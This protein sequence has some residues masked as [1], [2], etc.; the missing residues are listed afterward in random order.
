M[1]DQ[2]LAPLHFALLELCSMARVH[3]LEDWAGA[4]W[5]FRL[6]FKDVCKVLLMSE[7]LMPTTGAHLLCESIVVGNLLA[8]SH[9]L[10]SWDWLLKATSRTHSKMSHWSSCKV[11]AISSQS[12]ISIEFWEW[13]LKRR[14]ERDGWTWTMAWEL[15]GV[16]KWGSAIAPR[17]FI[18][19]NFCSF[20]TAHNSIA[21][22]VVG[23][24]VHRFC[25][26]LKKRELF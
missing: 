15:E 6:W 14:Q 12:K 17:T 3:E 11:W 22:D 4:C 2:R 25:P 16:K 7:C 9:Q 19:K 1:H 13:K 20:P 24:C 8:C 23:H 26:S 18:L 10:R 5:W 21:K